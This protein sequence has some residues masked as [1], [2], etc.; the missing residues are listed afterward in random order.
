[1]TLS[2]LPRKARTSSDKSPQEQL[3]WS[4]LIPVSLAARKDEDQDED[5]EFEEIGRAHV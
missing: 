5:E 1:M 2:L 3:L 4:I